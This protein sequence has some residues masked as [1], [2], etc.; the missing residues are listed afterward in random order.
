MNKFFANLKLN[1]QLWKI[2]W[3][4][5]TMICMFIF[6]TIAYLAAGLV[7]NNA[8]SGFQVFV[9]GVQN[10][11]VP[12]NAG[13]AATALIRAGS[14]LG[15]TPMCI[16]I[17]PFV[18]L[19]IYYIID[20]KIINKFPNVVRWKFWSRYFSFM[21][22]AAVLLIIGFILYAF[23]FNGMNWL[24]IIVNASSITNDNFS[25][26]VSGTGSICIIIATFIGLIWF[27]WTLGILMIWII[28]Q[29]SKLL[30]N[31]REKRLVKKMQKKEM[32]LNKKALMYE[33]K[34]KKIKNNK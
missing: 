25:N 23:S 1:R 34:Q 27:I 4:G 5:F 14:I 17:T 22:I 9:K 31:W 6:M 33:E 7:P 16:L 19:I 26:H 3:I 12:N 8:L 29:I 15:Y 24:N 10:L 2:F 13:T 18:I 20:E 11:Y 28:E 30:A 21:F 32:R